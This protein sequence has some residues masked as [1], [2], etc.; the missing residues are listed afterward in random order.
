M[1]EPVFIS[2][3]RCSTQKTWEVSLTQ[4]APKYQYCHTRGV[5]RRELCEIVH[6]FTCLFAHSTTR[7]H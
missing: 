5:E 2:V 6:S 4:K 7:A 1:S 3:P